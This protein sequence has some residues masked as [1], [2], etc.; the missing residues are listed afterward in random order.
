MCIEDSGKGVLQ[1]TTEHCTLHIGF[2]L[3]KKS[4]VSA[5]EVVLSFLLFDLAM[6]FLGYSMAF[7]DLAEMIYGLEDGLA[8]LHGV[9]VYIRVSTP[10]ECATSQSWDMSDR[11]SDISEAD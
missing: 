4:K 2:V 11:Y 3:S 6:A 10:S 1:K 5:Q 8:Y 7:D 9:H